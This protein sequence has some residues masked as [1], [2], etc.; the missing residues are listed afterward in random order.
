M[1]NYEM[2][3]LLPIVAKLAEKY[4]SKES[5]SVSYEKAR[6]FMEAALYCI[7]QCEENNR[8]ITGNRIPAMEAYQW[9]YER[10]I[11]K[12]KKTQIFYND[13]ITSFC[14]YGNENYHDTVTK[15]IPGFFKYYDVRFAPQE[16]IITMDYPTICPITDCCGIDAIAK[17]LEYISYE[18]KF[19]DAMP[20]DYIY[21]VLFRFQPGYRK[22]FYNICS[23][24][25][26]HIVCH[27]MI[28]KRVGKETTEEDYE[29]LTGV[30]LNN[31]CNGIKMKLSYLLEKLITE[32]YK[33]DSLMERYFQTDLKDFSTEICHAAKSG[34][35]QKVAPL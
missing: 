33:G 3:E 2:E 32:K 34:N 5:T 11:R 30:I 10:L 7:N 1:M 14:A 12:V 21:E 4:T 29:L 6:Q 13:M 8:L 22:Q 17:Y 9:G 19:M 25:L 28:G 18:Q 31:D 26:R 24:I 15:A 27:M 35:I 23:I 20:Q 16:T